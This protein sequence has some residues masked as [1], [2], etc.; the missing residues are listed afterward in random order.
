MPSTF[1]KVKKAKYK[2]EAYGYNIEVIYF[3]TLKPFDYKIVNKS[4]IKTKKLLVVE[5][6]SNHDGL[7]NL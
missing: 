3:N 2:L 6:L 4:L 5:D 1:E 7:L